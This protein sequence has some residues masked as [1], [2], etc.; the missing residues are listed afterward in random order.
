MA[1]RDHEEEVEALLTSGSHPPLGVRV[2]ARRLPA[3]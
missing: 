3:A 2:Q 1:A